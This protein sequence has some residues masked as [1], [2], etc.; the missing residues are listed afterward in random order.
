MQQNY[1]NSGFDRK[2]IL[3]AA[4]NSGDGFKSFYSEIFDREE[5]ERRYLIKGGPGTGK[6]TFMRSIAKKAQDAGLS[7]EYYACSSDPSSLDAVVIE[8]RV[9]VL[10]A[11]SPHCVEPELAGA[12]D[13]IVNLGAFW[14]S[15]GLREELERIDLLSGKKKECYKGAYRFLS[16][17]LEV[18]KRCREIA[19]P[20]INEGKMRAAVRR[21]AS[22]I[23]NGNGYSLRIGIRDSIGMKGRASTA[24]Y[25]SVAREVYYVVDAYKSG[26]LLLAMLVNEAMAKKN[27]IQVSFS[28]LDPSYPD[29]VLFEESMTAFILCEDKR[30]GGKY[31][32][33][34]RFVHMRGEDVK[35]V[36]GEYKA[37]VRIMQGLIQS[38]ADALAMAGEKHFEL[39]DIYKRYMDFDAL[40]R[41]TASFAENLTERLLREK[42]CTY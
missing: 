37:N 25:E 3:F 21:I 30:E 38:A 4:A 41:Y 18:E 7:V 10:D 20:Y 28:P 22:R 16:A 42:A 26:S 33:M 11:T 34:K 5:I 12:R 27:R 35:A 32:N 17:A 31:I 19:A 24:A 9:A 40:G 2:K 14:D 29:A 15:E 1:D 6:S 36:R 39:E 13:E 23:P 8:G